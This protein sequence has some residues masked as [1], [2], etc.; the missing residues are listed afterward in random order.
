MR[1]ILGNIRIIEKI[2]EPEARAEIVASLRMTTTDI[3]NRRTTDWKRG[4]IY[5]HALQDT[6]F[7]AIEAHPTDYD[8]IRENQACFVK[9]LDDYIEKFP[10]QEDP[11]MKQLFQTVFDVGT[12]AYWDQDRKFIERFHKVFS[13]LNE[14]VIKP[15][16]QVER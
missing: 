6:E 10:P 16:V 14:R 11:E 9:D 1:E 2:S 7:A 12:S 8:V 13:E 15:W 5:F 4:N 3:D